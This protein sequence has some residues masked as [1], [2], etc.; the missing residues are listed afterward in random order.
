MIWRHAQLILE[1][2]AECFIG[3]PALPSTSALL[4]ACAMLNMPDQL[5]KQGRFHIKRTKVR[6]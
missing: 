3:S 1:K 2:D 6:I 5:I 4:A